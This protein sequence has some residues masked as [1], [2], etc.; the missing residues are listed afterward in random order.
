MPI[1]SK[2]I[3]AQEKKV[4]ITS[5]TKNNFVEAAKNYL[6]EQEKKIRSDKK[7]QFIFFVL[8]FLVFYLLLN[9][10]VSLAP[11]G[12]FKGAVGQTLQSVLNTQGMNVNSIGF[13][14][15]IENNWVGM[16]TTSTCY[17]FTAEG[18]QLIISWLCTGVLEILLLVSAIL[19][20]FGISWTKKFWGITIAIISGALFNLLRLVITVNL[21]VSQNISVVELAHD[22]LFRVVLFVYIMVI[23]IAWFYW[24]MKED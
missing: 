21:V 12:V 1:K 17:S 20:S 11:Q 6:V 22:V 15:C 13:I 24:A 8:G 5:K 10:V 2:K 23:Y 3:R 7:K 9:G 4:R 16:E 18:K 14:D 19:A